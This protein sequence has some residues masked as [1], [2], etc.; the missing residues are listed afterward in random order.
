MLR[1]RSLGA[2]N[3]EKHMV[4]RHEYNQAQLM[5]ESFSLEQLKSIRSSVDSLIWSLRTNK[6]LHA[7]SKV[8]LVPELLE[9]ILLNLPFN[10]IFICMRV[11]TTFKKTIDGSSKLRLKALVAQTTELTSEP[12]Y[13]VLPTVSKLPIL[14]P[15][16]HPV[17]EDLGFSLRSSCFVDHGP[18]LDPEEQPQKVVWLCYRASVESLQESSRRVVK[19]KPESVVEGAIASNWTKYEEKGSW[20]RTWIT[21][22]PMLVRVCFVLGEGPGMPAEDL[23]RWLVYHD[24]ATMVRLFDIAVEARRSL[25]RRFAPTAVLRFFGFA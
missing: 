16:I 1:I 15:L 20:A 12:N 24:E 2:E 19:W 9:D 3:D 23:T 17:L 6:D 4:F 11:N 5:L 14:N 22:H 8:F 10:D 25:L 18:L 7:A 21:A 13:E